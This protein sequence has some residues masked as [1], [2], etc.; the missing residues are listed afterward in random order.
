MPTP[1]PDVKSIVHPSSI[2]P[3]ST[4]EPVPE[5][6]D[7]MPAIVHTLVVPALSVP[8]TQPHRSITKP[9]WL[10]DYMCNHSSFSSNPCIPRMFTPA[11]RLF[12]ANV[13]VVQ[14][15]RSFAQANQ[16]DDKRKA[17]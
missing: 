11:H 17:M 16:N 15:P 7:N 10:Q 9:A 1:I 3:Y 2:L 12:L 13:A 5:S 6:L 4:P 8:S 14:E